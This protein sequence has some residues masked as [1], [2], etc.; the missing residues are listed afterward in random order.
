LKFGYKTPEI[1]TRLCWRQRGGASIQKSLKFG[2]K[3]PEIPTRL[4]RLKMKSRAWKK[5][6]SSASWSRVYHVTVPWS[7]NKFLVQQPSRWR[8]SLR[9]LQ[10]GVIDPDL[11]PWSHFTSTSTFTLPPS[12][13]TTTFWCYRPRML[14]PQSR[15][16][17]LNLLAFFFWLEL[18]SSHVIWC[19]IPVITETWIMEPRP[20]AFLSFFVFCIIFI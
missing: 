18:S 10:S 9:P 2:Y 19:Y 3:T 14:V 15:L 1:P 8:S 6:K 20:G 7:L 5:K 16:A 12:W 13:T 11:V 4:W 17:H